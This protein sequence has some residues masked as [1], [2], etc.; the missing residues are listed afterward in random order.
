MCGASEPEP[1]LAQLEAITSHLI[2]VTSSQGVIESDKVS[3]EAITWAMSP[4]HIW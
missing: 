4:G 2:A 1:P 3:L